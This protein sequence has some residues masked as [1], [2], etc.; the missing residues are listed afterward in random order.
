MK[1]LFLLATF[2][3]L[4]G[5]QNKKAIIVE[6]QKELKKEITVLNDSL[7]REYNRLFESVKKLDQ[8]EHRTAIVIDSLTKRTRSLGVVIDAAKRDFDSLEMELKKY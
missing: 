7:K 4:M 8:K 5:C 1:S 6:R 3:L 2:C